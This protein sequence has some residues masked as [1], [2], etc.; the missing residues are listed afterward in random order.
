MFRILFTY[1]VPF[2]MPIAVYAAWV[3]YRARYADR[4]GG[5]APQFEQGPWPLL[6]FAGAL[7]ALAVLGVSAVMQGN[8]PEEGEYVPPYVE[9]GQIV[10]GHLEPKKK[11]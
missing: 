8:S 4:H 2:L 10:P 9:N 6:L 5:A 1:I 3:A 7:L 11:P